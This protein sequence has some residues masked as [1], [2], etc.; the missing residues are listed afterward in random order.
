[1][2]SYVIVSVKFYIL[3][4]SFLLIEIIFKNII[5]KAYAFN[6]IQSWLNVSGM[7][8]F[9][10]EN[11]DGVGFGLTVTSNDKNDNRWLIITAEYQ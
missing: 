1:M 10:H 3:I 8:D 7:I 5:I 9:T 2:N 11:L 6:S 4:Y